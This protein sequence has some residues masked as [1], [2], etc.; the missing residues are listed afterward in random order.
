[1]Y[2]RVIKTVKTFYWKLHYA[3]RGPYLFWTVLEKIL[4][5]KKE[6]ILRKLY[7]DKM[8]ALII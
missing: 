3:K 2:S 6:K 1:M 7:L 4:S 8:K 5:L